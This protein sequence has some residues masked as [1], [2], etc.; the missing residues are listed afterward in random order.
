MREEGRPFAEGAPGR[1]SDAGLSHSGRYNPAHEV[2]S[3]IHRART[4]GFREPHGRMDL[5]THLVAIPANG[6]AQ[7]K[8]EIVRDTPELI[9][10][11]IDPPLQNSRHRTPPPGM[12]NTN[13]PVLRI[14]QECRYTIRHGY[15]QQNPRRASDVSVGVRAEF[16]TGPSIRGAF[17]PASRNRS[18]TA[19][20]RG[21]PSM[22]R[23]FPAMDL[24]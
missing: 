22:G 3:E 13:R 20:R 8:M 1:F 7:M 14:H 6:G 21:F 16:E 5:F 24:P 2:P 12:D 4:I 23:H 19:I 15:A 17:R 18:R 9:A 11:E 10:Q